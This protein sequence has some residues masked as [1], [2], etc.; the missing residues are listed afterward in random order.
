MTLWNAADAALAT[1]GVAQ[2]DWQADGVSIDTRSIRAGDLFV[3]LKVARDGHEF[4]AA[5]LANGAAAAMVTHIPPGVPAD[6]PLLIVDDVQTALEALGRAGRARTTARI[7]AVTG[8]V[9]KTSTKEMLAGMLGDQGRT[10]ASVA[11][12]NNQW[13]VP[14]TLARMPQDT[15]FAVIEIGM[16][17]PGEITPLTQMTRPHVI[18]ITTVAPVH[19]EAFE[20][21]EGIA[22]EKAAILDGIEPNGVAVLNADLDQIDIL[23]AKAADAGARVVG[24]GH[25]ADDFRLNDAN[26][27]G[28]VIVVQASAHDM[29]LLFKLQTE[30]LHFAM[31][32]VG[33]LA[34]CEAMGADL[35]LA[36]LSLARWS[37]V[38]GRGAREVV[39]LD[40][41]QIELKL[42]L[43]DDSYNANPA[44]MAAA[45]AVLAQART[46]DNTGRVQKGRRIAFIG[47]M[48]ELGPR[49]RE[50]HVALAELDAMQQ[51]DVVHCIGPLMRALYDAL[52]EPQ[53]G[54]WFETS[55]EMAQGMH[56]RLDSGDVVLVKGSLSMNLARIVDAIRKM[57]HAEIHSET[58]DDE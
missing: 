30:G 46:Q 37:P 56:R 44:S 33:A 42:D 19:L 52:P 57:G 31:N 10:H 48:K 58:L 17:H 12:Y 21:I 7:V 8:S 26:V 47:D 24:F 6:A 55:A 54:L 5:A 29:P 45:L 14:L 9:G 27:Q 25:Q 34:V 28:E 50:L 40:P 38:K 22:R 3:A 13:G 11:S 51:L 49:G 15:E 20:G 39:R 4:V 35:A 23:T 18:M 53:R 36:T 1:G 43:I 16:N 32:A 41:V 2:G